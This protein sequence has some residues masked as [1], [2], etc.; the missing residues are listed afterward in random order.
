MK[1]IKK[2]YIIDIVLVFSLL[3]IA[4]SDKDVDNVDLSMTS[5][6]DTRL[7]LRESDLEAGTHHLRHAEIF[8]QYTNGYN[9]KILE[10]I[11][12][13]QATAPDGGGYFASIKAVPP[14]APVG[15]PLKIFNEL[16]FEPERSTS[17]CSGSTY[18]AFIEGLNLLYKD[19]K[20]ELSYPQFE[21][22]CM[23]EPEGGRREDTV[24]FWGK[25][26]DDGYGNHFALVQY[27]K[28]GKKINPVNARPG[29]FMN[30]SWTSGGGHSVVFL[31][32]YQDKEGKKNLLYW[33]SQT[34]TNGFGDEL[35]GLD[36]ISEVMTVRL[37]AP[38]SLFTFDVETK[39][40]RTLSGDKINW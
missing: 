39:V 23:Q 14:E 35:V 25:W 9:L 29:D 12:I 17:Y 30:I 5:D 20:P 40:N 21:A 16:L 1:I 24:K 13:V 11:D 37:V 18:A 4:C 15:Y 28:M 6:D 36:K 34:R 10:G 8:S 38:E 27:S 32:W 33:S 26:N 3:I 31:G 2:L 19:E 7:I 22:L